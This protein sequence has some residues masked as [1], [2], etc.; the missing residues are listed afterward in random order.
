MWLNRIQPFLVLVSLLLIN[1]LFLYFA[2]S[3]QVSI[4]Q[5]VLFPVLS[6]MLPLNLFLWMLLPE[7]GVHNQAYNSLLVAI[8]VVQAM[9]IYWLMTEL[10][11][12]WIEA[13]SLPV[14][15][16]SKVYQ[17]TFASTFSFL[18]TGFVL[19]LKLNQQRQLRVFNHSVVFILLLMA[20]ALNQYTQPG[21]LPWVSSMAALMVILA[22]VFDA[23]HIAYTDELTGIKGRRALNE[24][25]MGLGKNYAIAMVDIDHF[26]LFNDTYGHDLGDHVLR[27]VAQILNG[28]SGG[29]AYRFGGEEFALVFAGKSADSVV[30]ELE[31]LRL[32]I[33]QQVIYVELNDV[34]KNKKQQQSFKEVKVTISIGVAEADAEHS[35]PEQVIKFADEGLYKAKKSGRNKLIVSGV[36]ATPVKKTRARK[37]AAAKQAATK[38]G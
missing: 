13:I 16:E 24:S 22:L 21:V 1:L 23:H 15:A 3:E 31:R 35:T 26:K 19:S 37:P 33:S 4:A 10:P 30:Q 32:A 9:F 8:F 17:L 20:Y 34:K 28:V 36:K 12:Q 2:P 29:K 7:K 38:A 5:S 18:I 25:F 14:L 6:L 11:L 27:E